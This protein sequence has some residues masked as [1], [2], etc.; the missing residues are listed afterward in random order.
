MAQNTTNLN[1]LDD[2]L[3]E[4]REKR[5]GAYV[6]RKEY[7]RYLLFALLIIF[8]LFTLGT[9]GPLLYQKNAELFNND[10]TEVEV[11]MTDINNAPPPPPEE[12]DMPP[13]PPPPPKEEAPAPP[14]PPVETK[15]LLPPKPTPKEEM[16]E[17]DKT[18]NT[19]DDLKDAVI[20]KK[21]QEGEKATNPNQFVPPVTDPD[22]K[23]KGE[24]APIK[25]PEPPKPEPKKETPPPAEPD[26][27]KFIPAQKRPEPVNMDEI[28]A[29]IGYPALAREGGIEGE[30]T[31][32]ILVDE[33]G[34]YKK[35]IVLKQV[36]PLLLN[37]VQEHVS[38][39]RFTPAI[40]GEKPIAFWLVVPFKFKLQ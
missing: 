8:V 25:E 3:F 1:T 34:N 13:P 7:A 22:G 4:D 10:P 23:G 31:L 18:L 6:L 16:K 32:K 15:A 21:D 37:A 17:P 9:V 30:V 24:P 38:K 19:V 29:A 40:Q 35:H 26:P 20:D 39:L 5:F 27:N 12:E 2:I 28:K 36:H 11:N 33:N 14:P